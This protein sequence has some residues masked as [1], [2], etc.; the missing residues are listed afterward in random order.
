M[1]ANFEIAR[2]FS[3][4]ASMLEIGGDNPFKIRAYRKAADLINDLDGELS[5]MFP[6]GWNFTSI[7]GIGKEMSLKINEFFDTGEIQYH[8]EMLSKV[9][10]GPL[11]MLK[12]RGM[13]PKTVRLFCEA[14]IKCIDDLERLIHQN[15]GIEG[16]RGIGKKKAGSILE[17]VRFYKEN[18]SSHSLGVGIAAANFLCGEISGI[19][20]VTCVRPV[21]RLRRMCETVSE[22]ELLISFENTEGVKGESKFFKCL[23]EL[24]GMVGVEKIED[25]RFTKAFVF[26]SNVKIKT[27]VYLTGLE[28]FSLNLVRL[29]GSDSHWKKL[30]SLKN[31]GVS[32]S[33]AS[34]EDIYSGLGLSFIPP[35]LREDKGEIEAAKCGGLPR[36][37]QLSDIRGDLHTHTDWSDGRDSVEQMAAAAREMGYEYIALTDHSPSSSVANGLSVDRLFLKAEEV[38]KVNSRPDGVK[39]LMGAEV[40]IKPDGSL[41][42]PD[43]ILSELDFVTASIH[44]SFSQD[45]RSVT[46]RVV[47]AL[48]NPFVHALAPPDG[49]N[50][51]QTRSV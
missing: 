7:D 12:L 49:Q 22:I 4:I 46:K 21:G 37:V 38:K 29:T 16:I 8:K 36:L 41:D 10:R 44:S 30:S 42:Y 20:G 45:S 34:E 39:I 48:E 47:R 33:A 3:E 2:L 35:E 28:S 17:A 32:A 24:P 5:E 6:D 25:A 11:E 27:V 23:S 31:E 40:D 43:D 15:E 13:G 18:L 19:D 14:G 51:R 26:N 9:G 50:H 1:G